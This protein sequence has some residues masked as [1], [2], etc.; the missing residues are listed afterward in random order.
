MAYAKLHHHKQHPSAKLE[1][2]GVQENLK[3]IL[4]ISITPLNCLMARLDL[5]VTYFFIVSDVLPRNARNVIQLDAL[6]IL[7]VVSQVAKCTIHVQLTLLNLYQKVVKANHLQDTAN[8]MYPSRRWTK[9]STDAIG[10][11][12]CLNFNAMTFL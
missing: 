1:V 12:N 5:V 10:Q 4:N 11:Q 3:V 2:S 9:N 8:I 6:Q 7:R